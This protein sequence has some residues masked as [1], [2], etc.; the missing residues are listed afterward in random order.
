MPRANK[1][2]SKLLVV[3][4]LVLCATVHAEDRDKCVDE[5]V[6]YFVHADDPFPTSLTY[7]P[8]PCF[9]T[10][11]DFSS[12]GDIRLPVGDPM[13][14][15]R[16]RKESVKNDPVTADGEFLQSE[17]DL[18][19][20]GEG[21][22]YEFTRTYR[23]KGQHISDLGYSWEH[24]Y[25]QTLTFNCDGSATYL[26]GHLG[27]VEFQPNYSYPGN[28]L[29]NDRYRLFLQK[30]TAGDTITDWA[31]GNVSTFDPAGHL[32]SV[33]TPTGASLQVSW[34]H[35]TINKSYHYRVHSVTDTTGARTIYY[36]YFPTQTLPDV[37][38]LLQCLSLT[39]DC[40]SSLVRFQY[41]ASQ[42]ELASV[43]KGDETK[44]ISYKYHHGESVVSWMSTALA[45]ERCVSLCS[46]KS[47]GCQ[48]VDL[49]GSIQ[50]MCQVGDLQSCI[51]YREASCME[52]YC[53][54]NTDPLCFG[55]NCA[56]QGQYKQ[57]C[58]GQSA[59]DF[60]TDQ[61][62]WLKSYQSK[63]PFCTDYWN[64]GGDCA[65]NCVAFYKNN[66]Y[67]YTFGVP[68]DLNHNIEEIDDAFGRIVVK[69]WYGTNP[70]SISFD[71]VTQQQ[72]GD[73][74]MAY[75]QY[76]DLQLE[77]TYAGISPSPSTP[78]PVHVTTHADFRSVDVCP[79]MTCGDSGC[80]PAA[81]DTNGE[82]KQRP[83]F[84][85]IFTDIHGVVFTDYYNSDWDQIREINWGGP[86]TPAQTTDYNYG[87]VNG[88]NTDGLLTGIQY[89]SGERVC[90]ARNE[91]GA[92]TTI[93]H[94]PSSSYVGT[95]WRAEEYNYLGNSS[96][97]L[98]SYA[99]D[100]RST[101]G[102]LIYHGP[103]GNLQPT[104][105]EQA[106]N[107][108]V[109]IPTGFEYNGH[110]LP[111]KKTDAS[112]AVTK[113][114]QFDTLAAKPTLVTVDATGTSPV[115]TY[116]SFDPTFGMVQESG[117]VGGAAVHYAFDQSGRTLTVQR[118]NSPDDSWFT[119]T[120]GYQDGPQPIKISDQ[121]HTEIPVFDVWNDAINVMEWPAGSGELGRRT[122]HHYSAD[123]RPLEVVN[124]EGDSTIYSYDA[125]GRLV[126]IQRGYNP[127]LQ[128]ANW[129]SGCALE[130]SPPPGDPGLQTV[131]AW[132]YNSGGFL[133]SF[134]KDGVTYDVHVDGFGRIIEASNAVG[135]R[136]RKGYDR[137]GRVTWEAVYQDAYDPVCKKHVPPNCPE[138]IVPPYGYPQ[139]G[140]AGLVS[141]TEYAY[142]GL[143]RVTQFSR[144]HLEDRTKHVTTTAYDDVAR[145]VSVTEGSRTSTVTL[146]GAGRVVRRVLADRSVEN[147][148]YSNNGLTAVTT[149]QTNVGP[150][151]TERDYDGLQLLDAVTVNGQLVFSE[152]HDFDGKP[153]SRFK[154]ADGFRTFG[155]DSFRRNTES[156]L[157]SHARFPYQGISTVT[158]YGWDGDDRLT[159]VTDTLH[160]TTTFAFDGLGRVLHETDPLGRISSFTYLGGTKLASTA[161]LPSGTQRA[162]DYE[163]GRLVRSTIHVPSEPVD[164]VETF[165]YTSLGRM[166]TASITGAPFGID[167]TVTFAY[168]SLGRAF[169]E[170]NSYTNTWV[171]HNYDLYDQWK[172][173]WVGAA[174]AGTPQM[175]HAYDALL[176][177]A[178]VDVRGQRFA[179]FDYGPAGM[180]GPL[181]S[182]FPQIGE[183]SNWAYDG[184]GR[185]IGID[186]VGSDGQLRASRHDVF[187][188]D[189]ILRQRRYSSPNLPQP[190]SDLFQVDG[191]GKVSAENL[192]VPGVALLSGAVDNG[193]VDPYMQ[194][195]TSWRSFDVDWVGN[196][197]GVTTTSGY[198]TRQYNALNQLTSDS[199]ATSVQYDA[200]DN[201]TKYITSLSSPTTIFD[202]EKHPVSVDDPSGNIVRFSYDALGRRI[203]ESENGNWTFFVWDGNQIVAHGSTG[204]EIYL[205]VPGV[206]PD[207]HLAYDATTEGGLGFGNGPQVYLHHGPDKSL[208]AT[209]NQSG[210]LSTYTYSALGEP[211]LYGIAETG[212][213]VG[214]RFLFQG[215]LYDRW[216]GSY[217][218][219]AR[220]YDAGSGRFLS[221]DPLGTSAGPNLYGFASGNPLT[222]GDPTGLSPTRIIPWS[223]SELDLNARRIAHVQSLGPFKLQ[224][225][226]FLG[227]GNYLGYLVNLPL[228]VG[229]GLVLAVWHGAEAVNQGYVEE[230]SVQLTSGLLGVTAPFGAASASGI[231]ENSASVSPAVNAALEQGAQNAETADALQNLLDPYA[232]DHRTAMVVT[233]SDSSG[234]QS[235][236]AASSRGLSGEQASQA[237]SMGLTPLSNG[238]TQHAE[239]VGI[240]A[241]I[242]AQL[243]QAVLAASRPFCGVC[244]D[245]LLDAGFTIVGPRTAIK[246]Y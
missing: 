20:P 127:N 100:S 210:T 103:L 82:P 198:E 91:I 164:E 191:T 38:P 17:T 166:A 107:D 193:T 188:T 156:V 16:P 195:G 139:F 159:S 245:R 53:T 94:I 189:G 109:L 125:A 239:G 175:N 173:T 192:G 223:Q 241:T 214:N 49:C 26:D 116:M 144:W 43:V 62:Q 117:L 58:D 226:T 45:S 24:N 47:A 13:I 163:L 14:P 155:Y 56:D 76:H 113:F 187:G 93:L 222:F 112:G 242:A 51:R 216:T 83:A 152:D 219:R 57:F 10:F 87:V 172:S 218:M 11:P 168:D 134:T 176:R 48:N 98:S 95:D 89:P 149:A 244:T 73:D 66:S 145:T 42:G 140:D 142:D 206:G 12:T 190:L 1:F 225:Q 243:D 6:Q 230:G 184:R 35:V 77:Q 186:V 21:L 143:G 238:G 50:R 185:Q 201:L 54:N 200:A 220:E 138:S 81:D 182:S 78:D 31:T 101:A 131:A 34:E 27:A 85:M 97:I 236:F 32:V 44:G 86:G 174:Q 110:F 104:Y 69:N 71:R 64:G 221:T 88:N 147:T 8:G 65:Y 181:T 59:G 209:T 204:T 5:W 205:D 217:S 99:P 135:V 15:P 153:L 196:I 105:V 177:L 167:N 129:S 124:P 90:Y 235:G 84:A 211:K 171:S 3:L 137:L 128:V 122:C 199:A 240:E 52:Q 9:D 178:S 80:L 180:G 246:G 229:E 60:T 119:K 231:A 39:T 228:E 37:P 22:N 61:I 70:G 133:Q 194:I 28:F 130:H 162:N 197:R 227:H 232:Q 114:D 102:G 19:F 213:V 165:T 136:S 161:A 208:L 92:P 63:Y 233:G 215:M 146:D 148:V 203:A 158:T 75:F 126:L 106:V 40:Y 154:E 74:E 160:R 18:V 96:D 141:A 68:A 115:Q 132:S 111:S 2:G 79:S 55:N 72:S 46:P 212:P 67:A 25:Y 30:T 120:L 4:G 169:S 183:V 121:F 36:N 33:T 7:T 207:N 29:P 224:A 170:I 23:S 108:Y 118:R 234:A 202:A 237:E 151:V 179:Q 41:D 123:G 157:Q 150:I